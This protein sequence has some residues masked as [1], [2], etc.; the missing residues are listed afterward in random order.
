ML[1]ISPSMM[2]FAN[3]GLLE[4]IHEPYR[5]QELPTPDPFDFSGVVVLGGEVMFCT[6]TVDLYNC[7]FGI[8][9]LADE[10]SDLPNRMPPEVVV[11][12]EQ[13][14]NQLLCQ[15]LGQTPSWQNLYLLRT[16]PGGIRC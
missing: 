12:A 4:E 15:L 13:V 9:G 5:R 7:R 10:W 1:L 11:K 2:S 14:G 3:S 6:I 16:E 8:S